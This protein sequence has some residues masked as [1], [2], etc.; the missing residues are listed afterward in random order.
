[1][2]DWPR[3]RPGDVGA[4]AHVFADRLDDTVEL[5]HDDGHHLQRVRRVRAG[6]SITAADGYGR[7][8]AFVVDTASAGAVRILATY[9]I[10]HEPTLVPGLAVAFALTKERSPSSRCRSSPSSA[11]IASSS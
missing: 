6:E 5:A 7:W 4:T 3:G 11:S 10:V 1:M 8:R 2:V 9:S